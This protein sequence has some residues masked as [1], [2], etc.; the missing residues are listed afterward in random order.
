MLPTERA[1]RSTTS[2]TA[3]PGVLWSTFGRLARRLI[4]T[5]RK[6]Y[7]FQLQQLLCDLPAEEAG[8]LP[9]WL[10]ET[11]GPALP[12]PVTRRQLAAYFLEQWNWMH[13]HC[14]T[15]EVPA[16]PNRLE[17]HFGHLKLRMHMA[18]ASR[19]AGTRNFPCTVCHVCT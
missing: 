14:R 18:Q 16:G 17:R 12:A 1:W 2:S 9:S 11:V 3:V 13:I 5:V 8:I 7:K 6:R 15:P 4:P 19:G 10:A